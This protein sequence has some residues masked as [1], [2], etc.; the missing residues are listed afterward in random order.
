MWSPPS[1]ILA[2]RECLRQD[3]ENHSIKENILIKLTLQSSFPSSAFRFCHT[4]ASLCYVYQLHHTGNRTQRLKNTYGVFLKTA[5]W[6]TLTSE[7][8]QQVKNPLSNEGKNEGRKA[9]IMWIL[10]GQQ[11]WPHPVLQRTSRSWE[12]T[13]RRK[14]ESST[15]QEKKITFKSHLIFFKFNFAHLA[16]SK[17]CVYII[18]NLTDRW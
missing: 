6:L 4:R 8:S 3:K 16:K 5:N 15:N 11:F 7:R 13:I 17:T 14:L 1:W 9:D 2:E 10:L 12:T 18:S